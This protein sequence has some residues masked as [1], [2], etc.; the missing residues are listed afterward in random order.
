MT[1]DRLVENLPRTRLA[2]RDEHPKWTRF[3]PPRS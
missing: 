3:G 1:P 2:T